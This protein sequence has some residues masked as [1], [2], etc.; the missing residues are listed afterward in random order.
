MRIVVDTNVIISGLFFGG[1]PGKVIQYVLNGIFSP[2]ISEEILE[3]YISVIQRLSKDRQMS[4]SET[5]SGFLARATVIEPKTSL[6]LSRDPTDDKFINCAVDSHAVFIVSGDE[7]L[8]AL[9]KVKNVSIIT[10]KELCDGI[11]ILDV[12]DIDINEK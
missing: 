11:T 3:E 8:L 9:K 4:N 2:Y 7:D 1:Y 5:F 10:A 6:K 12:D